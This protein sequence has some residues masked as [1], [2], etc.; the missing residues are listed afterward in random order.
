M[1]K[2]PLT[3]T[4]SRSFLSFVSRRMTAH[5]FGLGLLWCL[6][7]LQH[8]PTVPDIRVYE[9]TLIMGPSVPQP[10]VF[11]Q[12]SIPIPLCL[13]CHQYGPFSVPLALPLVRGNVKLLT[14]CTPSPSS[15]LSFSSGTPRTTS[16]HSRF[17]YLS[18]SGT[19]AAALL[20][21][22]VCS[23]ASASFLVTPPGDA[24]MIR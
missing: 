3:K 7:I 22:L 2:I 4:S 10:F 13:R 1:L 6:S 5:A 9:N 19:I 21:Q 14:N 18:P 17:F 24:I 20:P 8:L 23:S 16:L 12:H 11:G 15:K